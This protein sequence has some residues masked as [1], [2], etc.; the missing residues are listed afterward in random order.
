MISILQLVHQLNKLDVLNMQRNYLAC[1]F[2]N[3]VDGKHDCQFVQKSL[4]ESELRVDCKDFSVP[5]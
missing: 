3:K 1:K 5:T 2:H 4:E